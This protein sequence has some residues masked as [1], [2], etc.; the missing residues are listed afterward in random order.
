MN[1]FKKIARAL[2]SKAA[3]E[4]KKYYTSA[5]IV[6][7][8]KST[9]TSGSLPKQLVPIKGIPV[10]VRSILAFEQCPLINEIIF[11]ASQEQIK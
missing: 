8:G 7:A 3:R 5:I 9:R 1:I 4:N 10:V 11:V 6:A 2:A